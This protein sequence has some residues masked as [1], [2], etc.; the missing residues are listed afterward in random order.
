M[1][2]SHVTAFL[3][4]FPHA[5]YHSRERLLTW[6]PRGNFDDALADEVIAM[7]E[8]D[9]NF[10]NVPFHRFTDLSL[11][12]DIHL[13]IGHVF[14]IAKLRRTVGEPVRSA[15]F[16][17]TTVGFGIARM[18]ESLMEGAVI[19]VRAFRERAAAAE[20]LDVPAPLLQPE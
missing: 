11:L 16:G 20:W 2:F 3:K 12:K 15:F 14:E 9:E 8:L 13:K 17:D 18:Y 1:K 10:E 5:R 6:S 7:L 4:A 19:H